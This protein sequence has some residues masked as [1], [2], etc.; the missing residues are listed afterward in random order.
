MRATTPGNCART[1]L[2]PLLESA[3]LRTAAG[4]LL[5]DARLTLSSFRTI[6]TA[7]TIVI[8]KAASIISTTRGEIRL[9]FSCNRMLLS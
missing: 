6:H 8:A 2:G 4:A 9:G 3:A 5:H 1:T 7:A